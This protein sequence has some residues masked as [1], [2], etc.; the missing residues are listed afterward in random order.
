MTQLL[1]LDVETT[2]LDPL[3]HEVASLAFI[4]AELEGD[5]LRAVAHFSSWLRCTGENADTD[6]LRVNGLDLARLAKAPAPADVLCQLTQYA[7]AVVVGHNVLF[8][9]EFLR[10]AHRRA[11]LIYPGWKYKVCTMSL[12]LAL[13]QAGLIRPLSLSLDGLAA[14]FGT[15]TQRRGHHQ[16]LEDVVITTEIYARLIGVLRK[17]G[18]A[19]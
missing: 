12:A 11:G 6:A 19:A 4:V 5:H 16:A 3:E 18:Y 15:V 13:R 9:L 1:F 8:D 10:E 17:D 2:G 7:D 14:Y